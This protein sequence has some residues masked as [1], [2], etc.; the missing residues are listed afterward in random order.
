MGDQ[1][2]SEKR[3]NLQTSAHMRWASGP[4]RTREAPQPWMNPMGLASTPVLADRNPARPLATRYAFEV[5]P[6]IP[7][8][9][10][11]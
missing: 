7:V 1:I 3:R 8:K 6:R 4:W 5:M 9:S 2:A 10:P 11:R